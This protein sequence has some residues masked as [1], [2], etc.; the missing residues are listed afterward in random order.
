MLFMNKHKK[1]LRHTEWVQAI[2]T[3]F[4]QSFLHQVSCS[5]IHWCKCPWSTN[6]AQRQSR[7]GSSVPEGIGLLVPAQL[8]PDAVGNGGDKL[9]AQAELWAQLQGKLLWGVLLLWHVPLK[10]VY[11]G[12]VSYMDVQLEIREE[13]GYLFP[14]AQRFVQGNWSDETEAEE[15]RAVTLSSSAELLNWIPNFSSK[16]TTQHC[17][18]RFSSSKGR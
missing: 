12:D 5:K 14:L 8:S 17:S 13:T 16:K 10:L 7:S 3:N 15:K 1:L 18:P 6:T 11:Q 9:P 2:R 4:K